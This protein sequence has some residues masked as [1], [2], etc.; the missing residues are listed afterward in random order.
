MKENILLKES[1]NRRGCKKS[2]DRKKAIRIR[3]LV[4][5]NFQNVLIWL[6]N[7][8]SFDFSVFL[9]LFATNKLRLSTYQRTPSGNLKKPLEGFFSSVC[10]F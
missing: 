10:P 3:I 4:N 7:L 6:K 1:K 8:I 2:P 5:F 9:S